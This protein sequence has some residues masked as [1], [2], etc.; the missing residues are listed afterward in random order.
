M[1]IILEN[2]L[3]NIETKPFRVFIVGV[4]GTPEALEQIR[5]GNIDGT[6]QQD[7]IAMG[8]KAVE[9]DVDA[10]NGKPAPADPILLQPVKTPI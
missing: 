10:L 4:D 7:P 9:L 8:A 3:R 1:L 2:C 5:Q 6:I